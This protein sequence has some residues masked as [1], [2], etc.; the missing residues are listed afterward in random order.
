MSFGTPTLSNVEISN[1]F[2][3]I[4]S[5]VVVIMAGV[6]VLAESVGVLNAQIQALKK[7]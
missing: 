3:D 6:S 4:R 2:D 5:R 7:Y 1:I